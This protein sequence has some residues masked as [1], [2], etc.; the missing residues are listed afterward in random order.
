M[1]EPA[2]AESKPANENNDPNLET[3][4]NEIQNTTQVEGDKTENPLDANNTIPDNENQQNDQPVN[5]PTDNQNKINNKESNKPA[6]AGD[7]PEIDKEKQENITPILEETVIVADTVVVDELIVD[8]T[9]AIDNDT[10]VKEQIKD[11]GDIVVEPVGDVTT[12]MTK[13]VVEEEINPLGEATTSSRLLLDDIVEDAMNLQEMMIDVKDALDKIFDDATLVEELA[14]PEED[15]QTFA[16]NIVSSIVDEATLRD[17][18]EEEIVEEESLP[19]FVHRYLNQQLDESLDKP[20]VICFD[21]LN[22][23]I[24]GVVPEGSKIL[25]IIRKILRFY[26]VLEAREELEEEEEALEESEGEVDFLCQEFEDPEEVA[27]TVV[28][29]TCR[30]ATGIIA[31]ILL[32]F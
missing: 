1:D 23:I 32:F 28:E 24:D 22:E 3:N 27:K 4:K 11:V 21:L 6:D 25:K 13:D 18:K 17:G 15:T 30:K 2:E 19:K 8:N 14:E 5:D 12:A 31:N 20:E 10:I 26:C 29:Q 9:I 16:K 7:I